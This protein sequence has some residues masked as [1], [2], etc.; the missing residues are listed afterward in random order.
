M[1]VDCGLEKYL[2]I[3]L[4]GKLKWENTFPVWVQGP[5]SE[6]SGRWLGDL[7]SSCLEFWCGG[8]SVSEKL[9][10]PHLSPLQVS[11]LLTLGVEL[12]HGRVNP[13]HSPLEFW[14]PF[15]KLNKPMAE[16]QD[17]SLSGW[18][19]WFSPAFV[20]VKLTFSS[21]RIWLPVT[22]SMG[23]VLP[24]GGTGCTRGSGGPQILALLHKGQNDEGEGIYS[25]HFTNILLQICT[26]PVASVSLSQKFL[27][28]LT[29]GIPDFLFIRPTQKIGVNSLWQPYEL[30]GGK[31]LITPWNEMTRQNQAE[32]LKV[33][34][35]SGPAS[36]A[37]FPKATQ[38]WECIP[39]SRHQ[40]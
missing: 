18:T 16:M 5:V 27:Y 38:T 37:S 35:A 7:F 39:W 13:F 11:E 24:G 29:P 30:Q 4:E 10:A 23:S 26:T 22:P 31:R 21:P 33:L 14:D 28:R 1:T 36:S 32:F 40:W 17:L 20:N 15:P 34:T 9:L 6:S 19:V 25:S 2:C 3:L 12:D 8:I